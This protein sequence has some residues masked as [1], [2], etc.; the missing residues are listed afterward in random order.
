MEML[1]IYFIFKHRLKED[2]RDFSIVKRYGL[3]I[4]GR[5]GKKRKNEMDG[6]PWFC[7]G[8]FLIVKGEDR[9]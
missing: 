1:H 8:F 3:G 9:C 2:A 4:I 5:Q 7:P 6:C